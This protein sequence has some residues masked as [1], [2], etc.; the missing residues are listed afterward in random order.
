MMNKIIL[1]LFTS[2]FFNGCNHSTIKKDNSIQKITPHSLNEKKDSLFIKEFSAYNEQDIGKENI[3]DNYSKIQIQKFS[4]KNLANLVSKKKVTCIIFWASWCK[5]CKMMLDS[6]YREIIKVHQKDVTFAIVSIST[7]LKD[8]QKELFKLNYFIQ[9][10]VLN[11]D[12]YKKNSEIDDFTVF[13]TYLKEQFPY[14]MFKIS[15]PYVLVINKNKKIISKD[16][17]PY[18]LNDLLFE[19]EK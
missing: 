19:V 9:T 6:A 4:S 12:N 15:V 18:V 16:T 10:Y 7:N 2:F 1:I 17:E 5:G 13:E 11:P 14:E 3:V 8:N